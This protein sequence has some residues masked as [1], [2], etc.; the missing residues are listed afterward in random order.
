MFRYSDSGYRALHVKKAHT[1]TVFVFHFLRFGPGPGPGPV[2][3]TAASLAQAAAWLKLRVESI[4]GKSFAFPMGSKTKN[5]QHSDSD[6]PAGAA[7]VE[8]AGAAAFVKRGRQEEKQKKEKKGTR[9]KRPR[10]E[11]RPRMPTPPP[12]RRPQR[13]PSPS[14]DTRDSSASHLRRAGA[15]ASR[16]AKAV[17]RVDAVSDSMFMPKNYKELLVDLLTQM[18]DGHMDGAKPEQG[19]AWFGRRFKQDH[20]AQSYLAGLADVRTWLETCPRDAKLFEGVVKR[21]GYRPGVQAGVER[22]LAQGPG[23]GRWGRAAAAGASPGPAGPGE[24]GGRRGAHR[25]AGASREDGGGGGGGGRP[26]RRPGK[27]GRTCARTPGSGPSRLLSPGGP[28]SSGSP[29]PPPSSPPKGFG[30]R[31]AEPLR[32]RRLIG[33]SG[34]AIA[35]PR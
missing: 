3:P 4:F 22:N 24:V 33:P 19:C 17:R 34:R 1:H 23:G 15:A 28:G 11:E 6:E 35:R 32:R 16:L 21:F 5:K 2:R 27:G 30:L 20:V 14:D 9:A 13:R 8:D 26:L 29:V 10:S 25:W 31:S 7:A 18:I 12:A